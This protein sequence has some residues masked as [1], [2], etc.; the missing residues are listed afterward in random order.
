MNN[1]KSGGVGVFLSYD[2]PAARTALS[3]YSILKRGDMPI[4]TMDMIDTMLEQTRQPGDLAT[5]LTFQEFLIIYTAVSLYAVTIS[6]YDAL[7]DAHREMARRLAQ[8]LYHKIAAK[9]AV[10]LVTPQWAGKKT[11][12]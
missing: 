1:A 12:D 6:D 2:D 5:R 3:V 8:M 10:V 7:D 4:P 9:H 11:A